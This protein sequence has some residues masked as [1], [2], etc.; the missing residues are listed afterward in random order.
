MAASTCSEPF[1]R[2][3]GKG[4]KKAINHISQCLLKDSSSLLK[5]ECAYCLVP[6]V[7]FETC[8]LTETLLKWT[9][10]KENIH[11]IDNHPNRSSSTQSRYLGTAL[12]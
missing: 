12:K 10:D 6:T 8:Q 5:H 4:D 11:F 1:L 9:R 2:S 3:E 7:V